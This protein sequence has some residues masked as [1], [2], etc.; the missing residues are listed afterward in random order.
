[1]LTG[2]YRLNPS[3]SDNVNDVVDR[4][5]SS[6]YSSNQDDR[7]RVNLK[8]RLTSPDMLVIEKRDK[9]I[10]IASSKSPQIRFDADGVARTE[11]TPNGRTIKVTAQTYYDGVSLNYQG[12]RINDFYVN[13]IPLSNGQLK[14]VR[15]LN[16]ENRNDTVTVASIYDKVDNTAQWS[17]VNNQNTGSNNQTFGDFV[18]PNNTKI[19]AVL[20]TPISSK[21]SQEGDPFTMQVTSPSDYNG[22]IIQGRVAKIERSG[23]VSGRANTSLEFDTIQMPNGQT[24]KFA[25]IVDEVRMASGERIAVNNEGTVRDNNQTTKTVTRAGIGAAL[26]AL[27]GA[28]AGGGQGAAIGA[29]VGAGAGA[30]TVFAQGRDDIELGQG[31]QV[32]ITASAPNN[33]NPN[34]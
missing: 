2:T 11:T 25:G 8:R 7:V 9:Q 16:L 19:T 4:A 17:T 28:I 23:R 30:G 10:T 18:I 6:L 27:I 13:F 22:A 12:D 24:Y 31:T 15:R 29:A 33:L 20:N 14:V 5:F 32:M 34:R 26:G 1:M 21:T 3:Q